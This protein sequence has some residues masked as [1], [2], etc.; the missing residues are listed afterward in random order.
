MSFGEDERTSRAKVWLVL[1]AHPRGFMKY[2]VRNTYAAV[3]CIAPAD[4]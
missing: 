2:A 1:T 3:G 4:K